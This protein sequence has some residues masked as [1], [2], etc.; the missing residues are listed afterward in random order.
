[1]P[2]TYLCTLVGLELLNKTLS[3][4]E[5]K[6]TNFICWKIYI[7]WCLC[8]ACYLGE[9]FLNRKYMHFSW[10]LK[11]FH[12][13]HIMK[14]FQKQEKFS[15]FFFFFCYLKNICLVRYVDATGVTNCWYVSYLWKC[16]HITKID[17]IKIMS[18]RQSQKYSFLIHVA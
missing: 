17:R 9:N 2:S 10:L 3:H 16:R 14:T 11:S 7:P 12:P 1:M 15:C 4:K 5:C 6:W 13:S 18:Y 8:I